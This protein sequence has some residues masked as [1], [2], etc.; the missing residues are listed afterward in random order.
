[1]PNTL[2]LLRIAFLTISTSIVSGCVTAPSTTPIGKLH[3]YVSMT[4]DIAVGDEKTVTAGDLV[5]TTTLQ[6]FGGARLENSQKIG[7]SGGARYVLDAGDILFL[8][9]A[10]NVGSI[11]CT[12]KIVE[13]LFT[14]E[15]TGRACFQ[16]TD[17]DGY[18]DKVFEP[19]DF[20][21]ELAFFS[22]DLFPEP[23][24]DKNG[25]EP[26]KYSLLE[27]QEHPKQEISLIY[28]GK[29]STFRG[30]AYIFDER[31]R[32]PGGDWKKIDDQNEVII[33]VSEEP[34]TFSATTFAGTITPTAGEKIKT[35]VTRAANAE[36]S[37]LSLT[38]TTKTRTYYYSY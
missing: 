22:T 13:V 30:S 34:L 8:A 31:V 5:G 28:R 21:S 1:M 23:V 24:T 33:P 37:E 2:L 26:I 29:R 19:T 11:Y 17:A 25:V 32:T 10:Q 3:A 4:S 6:A 12:M 7:I 36:K 16:D 38:I 27:K 14:G 9:Q 15:R 18:F 35:K 20:K